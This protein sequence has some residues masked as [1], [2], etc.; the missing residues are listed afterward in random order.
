MGWEG[1]ASAA[2]AAEAGILIS[3]GPRRR[4][5]AAVYPQN[6]L[7]SV[8]DFNHIPSGESEDLIQVIH[9]KFRIS[10]LQSNHA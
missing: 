10:Q 2:Q 6:K 1:P 9:L 7:L 8:Q 5:T 4:D 3:L